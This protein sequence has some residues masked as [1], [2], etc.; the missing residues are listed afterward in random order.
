MHITT[1]D[2]WLNLVTLT[3]LIVDIDSTFKI[4]EKRQDLIIGQ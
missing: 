4:D 2:T 1:Q 3:D